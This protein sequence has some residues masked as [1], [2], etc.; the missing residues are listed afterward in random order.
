MRRAVRLLDCAFPSALILNKTR[1]NLEIR[2][3]CAGSRKSSPR[4]LPAPCPA[5]YIYSVFCFF[6]LVRAEG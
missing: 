2:G 5:E 6:A 3:H 1:M 4:L